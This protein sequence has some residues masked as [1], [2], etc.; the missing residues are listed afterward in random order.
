[1]KHV[2]ILLLLLMGAITAQGQVTDPNPIRIYR[3]ADQVSIADSNGNNGQAYAFSNVTVRSINNLLR[4]TIVGQAGKYYKPSQFRNVSGVPYGSTADAAYLAYLLATPSGGGGGGGSTVVIADASQINTGTLAEERLPATVVKTGGTYSNPTFINALDPSRIS[5]NSLNRFTSDAEKEAWNNKQAQLV[6]GSNIKTINGASILGSGDL[7]IA[8]GSGSVTTS[9]TSLTAGTLDDARL[10]ANVVKTSGVYSNPGWITAFDPTRITQ[11]S[12][13]RF[14]SDNEKLAW[15]NKQD[16]LGFVPFNNADAL[17][18]TFTGAG[19]LTSRIGNNVTVTIPGGSSVIVDPSLNSSSS[20][21]VANSAV[22]SAINTLTNGLSTANTNIANN[23]S[24]ISTANNNIANNTTAIT[25]ANT[26]IATNAAGLTTAGTNISTNTAAITALNAT[27]ASL[28]AAVAA[29]SGTFTIAAPALTASNVT[30]TSL[31]L[32][33]PASTSATSY[34]IESATNSGFT[35]GLTTLTVTSALSYAVTGLAMG[36]TYWFRI[37]AAGGAGTSPSAYGTTSATTSSTLPVLATP[38]GL[39]ASAISSSAVGVSWTASSNATSY[40]LRYSTSSSMAG[41]TSVTTSATSYTI[42]GLSS[43]TPYYFDV[44]ASASGYTSSA[45]TAT[46]TATTQAETSYTVTRIVRGQ[47]MQS[48]FSVPVTS[49]F[50]QLKPTATQATTSTLGYTSQSLLT[51]TG[52]A[53]G[54]TLSI[55]APFAQVSGSLSGT[56]VANSLYPLDVYKGGW[57]VTASTPAQVT[58][59]NLDAT[60]KYRLLLY[61]VSQ[62]STGSTAFTVGGVTKEKVVNNNFGVAQGNEL[63]PSGALIE[64]K[65]LVP[66]GSN[67]ITLGITRGGTVGVGSA[68]VPWNTWVLEEYTGTRP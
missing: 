68:S 57:M 47:N 19:Q 16:A 55:T 14:V 15:N 65:N 58:F 20:N 25:T 60:K 39:I 9:A 4:V 43:S 13:Y 53:S 18:V 34:T 62:T 32:S 45:A 12:L 30:N 64:F 51:E 42:A 54:I 26:N 38:T 52:T 37:R 27:V 41:A 24:A 35:T 50:N 11:T 17:N 7:A 59:N 48:T 56:A 8:G 2:Q 28:Q 29:V 5:Q 46:V 66:D 23:T 67:V 33:W 49:P 22:A 10:S 1:M 61:A 6:S 3:F 21:A 44:S 36:T 31:L 63:D 40:T